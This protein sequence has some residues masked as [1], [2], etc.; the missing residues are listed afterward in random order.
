[1]VH[2]QIGRD[3]NNAETDEKLE[4]KFTDHAEQLDGNADRLYEHYEHELQQIQSATAEKTRALMKPMI[5]QLEAKRTTLQDGLNKL[6]REVEPQAKQTEASKAIKELDAAISRC[7]S[8]LNDPSRDYGGEGA[9]LRSKAESQMYLSEDCAK[10]ISSCLDIPE[11]EA[12]LARAIGQTRIQLRR[13]WDKD[14][15]SG[16][17]PEFKS[18]VKDE[19][20]NKNW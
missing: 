1:M 14:A 19:T 7:Q 10:I 4:A 16:Q 18:V 13:Q 20:R 8:I 12:E 3:D 2:D 6:E 5:D 11:L 17:R 9:R 15:A